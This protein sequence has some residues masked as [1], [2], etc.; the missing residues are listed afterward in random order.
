[1]SLRAILARR[2]A[3]PAPPPAQ[4][5]YTLSRR[6]TPSWMAD[7]L[8]RPDAHEPA[9]MQAAPPEPWSQSPFAPAASPAPRPARAVSPSSHVAPEGWPPA[10]APAPPAWPEPPARAAAPRQAEIRV[11]P[12]DGYG[13]GAGEARS[14]TQPVHAP[15]A[16]SPPPAPFVTPPPAEPARAYRSEPVPLPESEPVAPPIMVVAPEAPAPHRASTWAPDPALVPDG[17]WT[18]PIPPAGP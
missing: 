6:A 2:F 7:A 5:D 17:G 8:V 12:G 13:R 18:M 1:M 9:P 4:R 15:E 3:P 14:T 11:D 10:P 16:W